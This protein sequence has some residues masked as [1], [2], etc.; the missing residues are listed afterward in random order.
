MLG[1]AFYFVSD[2]K[3]AGIEILFPKKESV[4]VT[5]N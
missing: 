5:V 2:N 3:T 1:V 4:A